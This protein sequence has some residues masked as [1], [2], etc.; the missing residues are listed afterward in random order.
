[1]KALGLLLLVILH[2]GVGPAHRP[3][4]APAAAPAPQHGM[5]LPRGGGVPS[6]AACMALCGRPRPNRH[7]S[8]RVPPDLAGSLVLFELMCIAL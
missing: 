3:F 6:C 4:L 8:T 1:M 7:A 5:A 2:R